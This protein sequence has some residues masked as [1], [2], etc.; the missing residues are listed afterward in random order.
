MNAYQTAQKKI[1]ARLWDE[2]LD[3]LREQREDIIKNG[4][5]LDFIP[6]QTWRDGLG[7][8]LDEE[9]ASERKHRRGAPA[10]I[11]HT[12]PVKAAALALLVHA[13]GEGAVMV[14]PPSALD[15]MIYRRVA[16]EAR[17]LGF[18]LRGFVPAAWI[19]A[20]RALDYAAIVNGSPSKAVR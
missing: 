12:Y 17:V 9:I 4:Y 18:Y 1:V 13:I 16:I 20:A 3:V 7:D 11:E 2:L 10:S 15:T 19:A 14:N 6:D 5:P 8:L